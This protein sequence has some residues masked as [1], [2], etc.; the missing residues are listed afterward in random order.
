M[1]VQLDSMC[2]LFSRQSRWSTSNTLSP[3]V[4]VT[5]VVGR[6][7]PSAGTRGFLLSS[8]LSQLFR[9]VAQEMEKVQVALP[10]A[11]DVPGSTGM[12]LPSGTGSV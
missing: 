7:T 12:G 4:N 6:I 3:S 9:M 10:P 5:V 1:G 8:H 2:I 11:E